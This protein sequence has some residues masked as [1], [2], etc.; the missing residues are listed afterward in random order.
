MSQLANP[1]AASEPWNLVA[2]GYAETTMVVFKQYAEAAIAASNVKAGAVVLDVACGPGTLALE[3]AQTASKVHGIDFSA[4]MLAIFQDKIKQ[5]GHKHI[6]LHCGD[7]QSLP[8]AD[9]MF[10]AAFS[11]FGLMFFPDR[12]QGFAEIYRTLKPGGSIAVTSWAPVE[13][14]P[15]VQIM[16]GA[17]RAIK[18]DLPEPQKAIA[19]LENPEVF[20]Q[21]LHDA[22]FRNIEI[23]SVTKFFPVISIPK[24]WEGLVKG[25][26]P[27]QMLKKNMGEDLWREKEILAINYL[28]EALP[29]TPTE[30]PAEAWLGLAVK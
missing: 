18:P 20:K 4:S 15:A 2:G 27:I 13:I 21:E 19:S 6:D 25:S 8:Y 3:I 23:R 24:F 17:L 16:F 26:A 22:G 5:A 28:E 9:G 1:L 12:N 7:A 10:D 29:S 30:L 14:S 11:M